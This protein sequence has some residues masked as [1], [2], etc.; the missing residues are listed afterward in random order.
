MISPELEM[1]PIARR[2]VSAEELEMS[3]YAAS[4]MRGSI[5]C[6]FANGA[7]REKKHRERKTID[8]SELT[9]LPSNTLARVQRLLS[10]RSVRLRD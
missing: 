5:C 4:E 7:K 8:D 2:G 6:L 10:A 3:R 9:R 1:R